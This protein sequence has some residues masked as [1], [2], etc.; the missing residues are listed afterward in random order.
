MSHSLNA[1]TQQRLVAAL[2]RN[3][4]RL[5]DTASSFVQAVTRYSN[6]S[7]AG[8]SSDSAASTAA[9]ASGVPATNHSSSIS[10][11]TVNR[12]STPVT[13]AM[14]LQAEH[15]TQVAATDPQSRDPT[16]IAVAA[17][18]ANVRPGGTPASSANAANSETAM[19]RTKPVTSANAPASTAAMP[20]NQHEVSG[21]A[22]DSTTRHGWRVRST[23]Y[24]GAAA[25]TAAMAGTHPSGSADASTSPT[26]TASAQPVSSGNAATAGTAA[27]RQQQPAPETFDMVTST[28]LL[29]ERDAQQHT[30]PHAGAVTQ[31]LWAMLQQQPVAGQVGAIE[32]ALAAASVERDQ[33]QN[34][35][36]LEMLTLAI[37]NVT[38][39]LYA[40]E[41]GRASAA[42]VYVEAGVEA[43]LEGVLKVGTVHV[44]T[45]VPCTRCASLFILQPA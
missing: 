42:N 12:E 37:E 13:A 25:S 32:T 11:E 34:A 36:H 4:G 30:V 43:H 3:P 14:P 40:T 29:Q 33:V 18:D 21:S 9:D 19:P 6:S 20:S 8:R 45:G 31:Q 23:S 41:E 27:S 2:Q 22:A 15:A 17:A 44:V 10:R 38:L 16:A 1:A 35:V 5:S 24:A 26:A 7:N 28:E 39:K